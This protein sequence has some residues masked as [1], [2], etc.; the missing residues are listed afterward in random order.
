MSVLSAPN[1]TGRGP[2]DVTV[3]VVVGGADAGSTLPKSTLVELRL[4]MV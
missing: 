2:F 4:R 1:T 3:I